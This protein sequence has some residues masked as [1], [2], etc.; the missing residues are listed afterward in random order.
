MIENNYLS[1]NDSDVYIYPLNQNEI[2]ESL[3]VIHNCIRVLNAA[4]YTPE[5]IEIIVGTYDRT[6]LRSGNVFVAKQN[7]HI[8]G[9][10]KISGLNVIGIPRIDAVFIDPNFIRQGIGRKLVSVLE[11]KAYEAKAKELLV[12]S[13]LTAKEFYL[14]LGYESISELNISG[15]IPCIMMRKTLRE[16]TPIDIIQNIFVFVVPVLILILIFFF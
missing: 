6:I 11:A 13:S 9:V 2:Y 12:C 16:T 10:A 7:N 15:N 8:I 1:D 3:A 4:D 5:Q 14:S